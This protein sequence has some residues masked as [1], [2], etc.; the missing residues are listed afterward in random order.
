M[1]Y[2]YDAFISFAWKDLARARRLHEQLTERGYDTWYAERNMRAGDDLP[3]KLWDGL[4]RS[5][6]VF[7]IHSRHYAGAPWAERELSVA[8]SD[9]INSRTT[10]IVFLTFDEAAVPYG[11]RQKL[12]VDFRD[13]KTHPLERLA[14][15]LDEASGAVIGG[16][17][18]AMREARE[19]EAIRQCAHRLSAIARRRHELAALR[20]VSEI[21]LDPPQSHH[22]A[23]SAAWALG[24]IGVWDASD[25]F[26][27]EIQGVVERC[28]AAGDKRLIN[29]MAYICGEMAR[30]SVNAGLRRWADALV[31]LHAAAEN[32]DVSVPF[33]FTRERIDGLRGTG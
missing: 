15:L 2:L 32:A 29:H 17:A 25:E 8:T 12:H 30:A 14:A 28:I 13:R 19:I 9:E 1:N 24:D 31:T 11:M 6:Y 20:A 16:V 4:E 23:D 21:L 22:V 33:A 5:R 27:R 3:K 26:A 18:R 7:V 10:K